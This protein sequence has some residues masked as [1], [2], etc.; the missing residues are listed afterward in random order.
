VF[1]MMKRD[2]ITVSKTDY[3]TE[4]RDRLALVYDTFLDFEDGDYEGFV[5][6]LVRCRYVELKEGLIN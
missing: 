4:V 2:F 6:E 3:M 1:Q 5:R